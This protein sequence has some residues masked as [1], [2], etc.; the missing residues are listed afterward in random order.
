M[1]ACTD[2]YFFGREA[3]ESTECSARLPQGNVRYGLDKELAE[4]AAAKYDTGLEGECRAW[5]EN[6]TG[7]KLGEYSLQEE[8]K[9]GVVLCHLINTIKPG[10]RG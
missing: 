3:A 10:A 6:V 7:D 1:H 2:E 8:L 5:I 4:K 9:N